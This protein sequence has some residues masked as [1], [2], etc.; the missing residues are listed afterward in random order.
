MNPVH[1]NTPAVQYVSRLQSYLASQG[2]GKLA[3]L[4]GRYYAMDRDKRYKRTKL[5]FEGLVKGEGERVSSD[6]L[7][8]VSG[9]THC[10]H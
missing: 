3:T 2:Y 6:G 10:T 1:A 4:T 7:I 8:Q 9:Y 5:A